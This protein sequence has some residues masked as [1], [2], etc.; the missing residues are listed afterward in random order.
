[1]K[2]GKL[3]IK[4]FKTWNIKSCLPF[5]YS[6][7]LSF[8]SAHSHL[9]V[10]S[11]P[12]QPNED[13]SYMK[14]V[15][16]AN[17]LPEKEEYDY[18][19]IGG[20]TASCPLAVTISSN[21]SV[22]LL[23]RGSV[24]YNFST[25]LNIQ[26]LSNVF[27]NDDD[28]ENPFQRFISEDGV[29]NI[30]GWILGGGSMINAGFYSRAHKE[31]FEMQ[32]M[33]WD[34]EMVEQ[35]Y[36]CV[37]ETVVSRPSLSSWQSAFRSALLESG[38]GPDN[39]FDLRNLVGTKIGGSIFGREGNRHGAVELLNKAN[40]VNLKVVVR[41]KVERII[42]FGLSA[43]EVS[44]SDSKG[45]LHTTFIH[46]KGEIIVTAGAIGSP[47][48]LLLSGVGPKSNLSS[49]K[50]PVVLHEPHVGQ[51]MSDKP[52][53]GTVAVLPFPLPTSTVEVVGTLE[54][55]TYFESLSSFL[56][57]SIP[58]SF[59]LLPPQSTSVNMS[60]V[61]IGGKF[62]K[63]DSVGS[64][65]LNAEMSPIVRFN[66]Y[67]H[68][69]DLAQCVRGL[70]KIADLLKTQTIENIKTN[71]LEGKKTL[72][73]LGAP[74]PENMA[75]DI[76]VGEYCRRTVTTFWHYHGGCLVGKV[77]DGNYRVIGIENLRVV[78]GS[79]FSDSP[80]TNPMATVMMLGRYVGLKM[81][82][83]RLS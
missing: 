7:Y 75:D 42:F 70:R 79:T 37:E 45:K 35:A 31:F 54:G 76:F 64:L 63:V 71:D 57:F 22:L 77:V 20:G 24:P 25:V 13:V 53:F 52:R 65:Q 51:F 83:E 82:R 19:I 73:F 60:L 9:G 62:T 40:P 16:D 1:M 44:Y 67:S 43:N 32:G 41:A 3:P 58:P 26:G 8:I 47:Q 27:T 81:L 6:A 39:D 30:R 50:L 11:S 28:G 69:H 38:V 61:A 15:Y 23:E 10:S 66:Y 17:N 18:I 68:P 21:F 2:I 29:E 33:E 12:I 48:L 78:D 5:S 55:N 36:K 74:L 72:R 49:L 14:F 34:M 59:A 80:G 56:P 4:L 46:N